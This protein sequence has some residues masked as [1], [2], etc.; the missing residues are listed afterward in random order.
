MGLKGAARRNLSGHCSL[1]VAKSPPRLR[2]KSRARAPKRGL[3]DFLKKKPDPH[4]KGSQH[5][6]SK[7]SELP[8]SGPQSADGVLASTPENISQASLRGSDACDPTPTVI[9]VDEEDS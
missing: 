4:P 8:K 2:V 5:Q 6:P 7:K 3:W 9:D 1:I